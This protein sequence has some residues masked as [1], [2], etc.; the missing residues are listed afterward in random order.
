MVNEQWTERMFIYTCSYTVVKLG[1]VAAVSRRWS[2]KVAKKTH[3]H[4]TTLATFELDGW[5]RG[6]SS[7]YTHI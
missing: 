5:Y 4:N 6:N 7:L 2:E 3:I 1:A